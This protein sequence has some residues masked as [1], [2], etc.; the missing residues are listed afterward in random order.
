MGLNIKILFYLIITMMVVNFLMVL[1][2]QRDIFNC[3]IA[4]SVVY[5]IVTLFAVDLSSRAKLVFNCLNVVIFALFFLG[6]TLKIY[7]ILV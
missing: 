5:L 4:N 1:T 6:F 7:Q 2:G 3:F